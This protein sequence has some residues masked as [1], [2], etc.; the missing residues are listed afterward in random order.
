MSLE[1]YKADPWRAEKLHGAYSESAFAIKP[2]PEFATSEVVVSSLYRALGFEHFSERSVIQNTGPFQKASSS[3]GTPLN[4]S[5]SNE[6]WRTVLYNALASPKQSNQSTRRVLQMTPLVPDAN[7]YSGSARLAGN[8]WNPGAL[9]KRII[10]MGTVDESEASELWSLLFGALSVDSKDDA[11]A[12]WLQEEFTKRKP[13][14]V[15]TAW[16]QIPWK[17]DSTDVSAED[18]SLLRFPAQQFVIDIRSVIAAKSAMTRRQWISLFD[19]VVR[20]GAVSHVIWLCGV[21]SRLWE[22][23]SRIIAGMADAPE[24][25]EELRKVVFSSTKHNLNYGAVVLPAIKNIVSSYLSARLGLNILLWQLE[26]FGV[27]ISPL[28]SSGEILTFFRQLQEHR[29]ALAEANVLGEYQRIRDDADHARTL[30]CKKGI[31]SNLI[32]FARYSLGRRQTAESTLRSYDQ[33]YV[34][35]KR[36]AANNSPWIMSLGPVALLALVH[37]CLRQYRGPR[38]VRHLSEHLSL[39]GIT[40]SVDNI[41]ASELGK[42]LR[43][44]GLILDSPD[45]ESGILLVPPFELSEIEVSA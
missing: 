20:I 1:N 22:Y 8:P 29:S 7:L 11:W 25:V 45:A 19:A 36:G 21:N 6:T 17:Q 5:V 18:K 13:P 24:S 33:S 10:Q 31:G 2:A 4:G 3:S 12:R 40:L 39:Y 28:N 44:L 30:A 26:E 35:N 27:T 32:E 41:S 9:V 23:A 34:L 38:S 43:M 14:T 42:E 15:S 16:N 37:C